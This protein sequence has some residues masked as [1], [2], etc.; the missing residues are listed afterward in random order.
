MTTTKEQATPKKN[1]NV[2]MQCIKFYLINQKLTL[3]QPAVHQ[4]A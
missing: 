3:L 1:G 2:M 4:V